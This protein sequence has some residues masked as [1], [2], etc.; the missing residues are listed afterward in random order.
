MNLSTIDDKMDY[1]LDNDISKEDLTSLMIR[2]AHL[3]YIE[4]ELIAFKIK[5]LARGGKMLPLVRDFFNQGTIEKRTF[6]KR[7]GS[8]E[9]RQLECLPRPDDDSLIAIIDIRRSEKKMKRLYS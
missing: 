2:P 5:L 7:L 1:L 9:L 6:I 3:N 4:T 8:D